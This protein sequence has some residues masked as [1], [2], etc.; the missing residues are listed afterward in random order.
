MFFWILP[1]AQSLGMNALRF[2]I[3]IAAMILGIIVSL[4]LI[5]HYEASAVAWGLF[6]GN[7]FITFAFIY[8]ARKTIARLKQALPAPV[9]ISSEPV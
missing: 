8:F 3:Y 4:L 6:A 2:R 9:P 7:F 5:N 1:L